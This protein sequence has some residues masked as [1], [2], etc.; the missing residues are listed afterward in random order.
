MLVLFVA[1][2]GP[3]PGWAASLFWFLLYDVIWG[4]FTF[5]SPAFDTALLEFLFNLIVLGS[6]LLSLRPERIADLRENTP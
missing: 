5:H 4:D 2:L 6:V 1:V 3:L